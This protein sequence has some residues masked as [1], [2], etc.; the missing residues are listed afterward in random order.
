MLVEEQLPVKAISA[1]TKNGLNEKEVYSLLIP[2]RT[3]QHR[4][5][6]KERLS[7]EES[8]RAVRV[9]RILA[10][11]AQVFG[12]QDIAMQELRS[13]KSLFGDH[14]PLEML[15]TEAGGRLV[16]EWLYQIDE[17]MVA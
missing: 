5:A 12:D 6:R 8:D 11:A 13:T 15:A 17:G 14:T 4:R 2:R 1:L 9:A 7:I 3:L 10:L 16:E